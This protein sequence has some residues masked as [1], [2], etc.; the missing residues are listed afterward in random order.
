[1][2]KKNQNI[3]FYKHKNCLHEGWIKKN[4]IQRENIDFD[5]S[6]VLIK[7]ISN[8]DKVNSNDVNTWL[9]IPYKHF[10]S[11][12]CPNLKGDGTNH[13]LEDCR[14]YQRSQYKRLQNGKLL[15]KYERNYNIKYH[16]F[17]KLYKPIDYD[18]FFYIKLPR[19]VK[20]KRGLNGVR[21]NRFK[22]GMY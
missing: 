5:K 1:M 15:N 22:N 10:F 6:Y 2:I 8:Y 9:R 19:P 3:K 13:T 12:K 18:I 11:C 7:R 21:I 14:H 20:T 17:K 16:R 4:N